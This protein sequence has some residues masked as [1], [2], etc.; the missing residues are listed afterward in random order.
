[1]R[2]CLSLGGLDELAAKIDAV[3]NMSC[4]ESFAGNLFNLAAFVLVVSS[5]Q[6]VLQMLWR[7]E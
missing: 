5:L 2:V 7:P 3:S 1:M 4:S 6:P